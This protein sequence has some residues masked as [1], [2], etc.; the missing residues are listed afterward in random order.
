MSEEKNTMYR[1]FLIVRCERCGRTRTF[2]SRE[3]TDGHRCNECRWLTKLRDLVVVEMQCPVCGKGWH[4]K[5]NSTRSTVTACCVACGTEMTAD[6]NPFRNRYVTQE[7][8][9]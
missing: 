4:Y 3:G 8:R 9:E 6:W 7:E 2:R 1:G 5:T